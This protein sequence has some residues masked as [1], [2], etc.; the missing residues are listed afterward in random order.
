MKVKKRSEKPERVVN[1]KKK[2]VI[3]KIT[4]LLMY[5]GIIVHCFSQKELNQ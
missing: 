3:K 4:K 5:C 2:N 1:E